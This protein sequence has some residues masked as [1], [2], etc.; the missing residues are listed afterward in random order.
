[1]AAD[2]GRDDPAGAE[3]G[4]GSAVGVVADDPEVGP[5][6]A[7]SVRPTATSPPS[8]NSAAS[9]AWSPAPPRSVV[10]IP[11]VPKLV[12]R[13]PSGS[14]RVSAK[15]DAVPIS[16]EPAVTMP[17]LGW[18]TTAS[19][20]PTPQSAVDTRP[21]LPN[22]MSRPEG[23]AI[24]AQCTAMSLTFAPLTC[25]VPCSTAQIWPGLCGWALTLTS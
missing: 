14:W 12:S 11:F 18:I 22:V 16:R 24:V 4:V 9:N 13:V 21:P 23:V 19:P 17:P 15:S 5:L 25:P 6:P 8:D 7:A 3:R 20:C 10:A 2:V 1:L